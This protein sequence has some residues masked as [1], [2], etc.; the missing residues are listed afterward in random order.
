MREYIKIN[1][2]ALEKRKK[3]DVRYIA[4]KEEETS[5]ESGDFSEVISG[6]VSKEALQD[7][8]KGTSKGASE[9]EVSNDELL[10]TDRV[11]EKFSDGE[12]EKFSDGEL[13]VEEDEAS[14]DELEDYEEEEFP[15]DEEK[16]EFSGDEEIEEDRD[17]EEEEEE[18]KELD[19]SSDSSGS[20]ELKF[21]ADELI[22]TSNDIL[23]ENVDFNIEQI[24][25]VLLSAVKRVNGET[26][27]E[28][29]KSVTGAAFSKRSSRF[30]LNFSDLRISVSTERNLFLAAHYSPADLSFITDFDLFKE[31]LDIVQKSFVTRGRPLI[32]FKE[33]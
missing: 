31:K 27:D 25:K 24:S 14:D 3:L 2:K 9:Y 22:K 4:S 32:S 6:E 33:D 10:D 13:E 17:G 5:I 18:E 7:T 8:S 23:V 30:L 21:T 20:S 26:D 19:D 12:L 15:D 29:L 28:K 16:L 1:E 11:S